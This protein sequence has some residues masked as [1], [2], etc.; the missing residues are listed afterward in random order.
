MSYC[1]GYGFRGVWSG[2]FLWSCLQFVGINL[3]IMAKIKINWVEVIKVVITAL[4]GGL[5]G[6][7]A[8]MM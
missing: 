6:G 2:S 8:T 4:L 1:M 7:A 3:N 5:G